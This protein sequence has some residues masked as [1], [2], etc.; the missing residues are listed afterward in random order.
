MLARL[1]ELVSPRRSS[2]TNAGALYQQQLVRGSIC[3]RKEENHATYLRSWI[4]ISALG[5]LGGS[6]CWGT[7]GDCDLPKRLRFRVFVLQNR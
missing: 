4:V 2:G 3:G 1:Q 5:V 7:V 6:F